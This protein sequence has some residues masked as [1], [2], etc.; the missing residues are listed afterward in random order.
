MPALAAESRVQI[1]PIWFDALEF[2]GALARIAVLAASRGS[3]QIVTANVRFL[4]LARRSPDLAA[5]VNAASAVVADGMPVLWLSRLA[6]R[7]LPARVTG[8]DLLEACCALAVSSG[9]PVYLLGGR[10]GVAEQAASALVGRHPGLTVAGT[11]HGYL[12][13]AEEPAMVDG[14]RATRARLLFVGMGCPRQEFWISRNLV[15]LGV[16][17]CIGI[18]GTLD[19]AAGLL[20][21]APPLWQRTGFEWLYRLRQEPRRLWKRYLLEDL[22]TVG[23]LAA[24]SLLR[25]LHGNG[26]RT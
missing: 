11:H 24:Q 19:V 18:G 25:R 17:V 12:S 2:E 22:P 8:V 6:G 14:I 10:P 23:L 3:H 26:R 15:Q 5:V 16:P 1:G 21:R 4:T 13:A 7:G 9:W 20:L